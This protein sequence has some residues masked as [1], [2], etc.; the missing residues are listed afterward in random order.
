MKL[1]DI[2]FETVDWLALNGEEHKGDTG[3]AI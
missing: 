3:V 1:A 2:P